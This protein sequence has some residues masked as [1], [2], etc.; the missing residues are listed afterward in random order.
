M[1]LGYNELEAASGLRFSF[2]PWLE[3]KDLEPLPALLEASMAELEAARS[4]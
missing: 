1:A 3:Q 2:G 4:A